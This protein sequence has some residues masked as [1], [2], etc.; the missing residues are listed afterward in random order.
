MIR[1][2]PTRSNGD[3]KLKRKKYTL[4][5]KVILILDGGLEE[6]SKILKVWEKI[7]RSSKMKNEKLRSSEKW[8]FSCKEI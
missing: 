7:L 3:E 2:E 6:G 1:I 8:Y 5:L 4:T